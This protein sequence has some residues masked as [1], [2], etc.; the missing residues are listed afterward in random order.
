MT[1]IGQHASDPP[2]VFPRQRDA[3]DLIRRS[4]SPQSPAPAR[5]YHERGMTLCGLWS[6]LTNP[7]LP[8]WCCRC[9]TPMEVK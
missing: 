8:G 2:P 1:L 6:H 3:D 9:G 4:A 5:V 7:T